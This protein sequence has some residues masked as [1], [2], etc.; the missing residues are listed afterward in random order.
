MEDLILRNSMQ[1][2]DLIEEVEKLADN[3]PF[4]NSKFQNQE[5]VVKRNITKGR[6]FRDGL[7]SLSNKINALR[8]AHYKRKLE[9]LEIKTKKLEIKK[10]DKSIKVEECEIE[11]E[12]LECEI[13]KINIEIEQSLSHRNHS[14]KII[15]DAVVEVCDLYE[16]V[17][18]LPKYTREEFEAEEHEHIT[19]L[20]KKELLGISESVEKLMSLGVNIDNG[21][22][23]LLA[24]DTFKKIKRM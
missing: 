3:V 1:L 8:E 15:K 19:L 4:G 9:D 12:I 20:Y 5:L 16:E 7:L 13:E 2:S 23:K 6:Q 24:D 18:K 17:K 11:K 10:I 14:D 22:Q 21:Q